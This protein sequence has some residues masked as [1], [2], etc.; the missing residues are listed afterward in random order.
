[1]ETLRHHWLIVSFNLISQIMITCPKLKV[2]DVQPYSSSALMCSPCFQPLLSS[3]VSLARY[4]S[5]LFSLSSVHRHHRVSNPCKSL[6][7]IKIV[8]NLDCF[9]D[10]GT[11][12]RTN[13][14][15]SGCNLLCFILC[16]MVDCTSLIWNVRQRRRI[17][18][19]YKALV[20]KYL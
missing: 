7:K 16:G 15:W 10:R 9:I 17:F 12:D 5:L 19:Q 3:I 13:L 18:L 8:S 2:S 14:I 20:W 1:M 11:V 4:R 6:C